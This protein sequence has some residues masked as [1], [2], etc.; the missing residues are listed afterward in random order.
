MIHEMVSWR[1]LDQATPAEADWPVLVRPQKPEPGLGGLQA[2]LAGSFDP[3]LCYWRALP[4]MLFRR[5]PMCAVQCSGPKD[6]WVPLT[7]LASWEAFE[8]GG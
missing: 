5:E 1:E 8:E 2:F 7:E 4:Q 3:G 6:L